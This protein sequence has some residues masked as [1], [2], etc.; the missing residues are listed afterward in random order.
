VRAAR[1]LRVLVAG[2]ASLLLSAALAVFFRSSALAH[3]GWTDWAVRGGGVVVVAAATFAFLR[4]LSDRLFAPDG[5]RLLEAI[6]EVRERVLRARTLEQLAEAALPPLR[7]G[8]RAAVEAPRLVS[9][10]PGREA[11][12]DAAGVGH[13]EARAFSPAILERLTQRP[14]EVILARP[15]LESAVRRPD[16]RALVGALNDLDALCVVPLTSE[17]GPDALEGALVIPRGARRAA[18]T[19][20]EIAELERLG[21]ELGVRLSAWAAASRAQER[22]GKAMLEITR[23][24]ERVAA[25]EDELADRGRPGVE[26]PAAAALRVCAALARRAPRARGVRAPRHA[27]LRRDREGHRARAVGRA[28]ARS[29]PPRWPAA[30]VARL[31]R[32]RGGRR[33]GARARGAPRGRAR[34][35]GAPRRRR[36]AARGAGAPG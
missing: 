11:R 1:T 36:A 33:R 15:I 9:L 19:L 14:G 23:L 31:R 35:A 27:S 2:A 20:E 22:A 26:A 24:E 21:R 7:R 10:D 17:P 13:V 8:L 25:L 29:R 12:V 32:A 16:L 3:A 28:R 4:A 6:G 5:G 18:V 34:H 30:R